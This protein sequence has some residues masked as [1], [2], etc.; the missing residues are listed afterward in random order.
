MPVADRRCAI[1]AKW[2]GFR[3]ILG[4]GIEKIGVLCYTQTVEKPLRG[5]PT[6]V[7]SLLRPG[8][9]GRRPTI[10]T[11]RS[12]RCIFCQVHAPAENDFNFFRRRSGELKRDFFDKLILRLSD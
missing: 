1:P 2:S 8:I 10:P 11:L 7:C 12:L 5:F 4:T 9:V 3:E 6:E